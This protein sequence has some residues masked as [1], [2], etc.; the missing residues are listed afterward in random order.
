MQGHA[1]DLGAAAEVSSPVWLQLPVGHTPNGAEEDEAVE[2]EP[3]KIALPSREGGAQHSPLGGDW[4][5]GAILMSEA[6]PSGSPHAASAWPPMQLSLASALPPSPTSPGCDAWA[7]VSPPGFGVP[8]SPGSA[9]HH[10]G[11]CRPC[12][13]FWKPSGC[14]NGSDCAYCHL[15]P[16]GAGKA[17]A[18]AR[19]QEAALQRWRGAE[20]G[21]E[22]AAWAAMNFFATLEAARAFEVHEASPKLGSHTGRSSD[23]ETVAHASSAHSDEGELLAASSGTDEQRQQEDG[24]QLSAIANP[25]SALHAV[26]RCSPCAW[27]WKAV[28]CHRGPSCDHCHLCP[29]DERKNRK[30][31]KKSVLA[32][33]ERSPVST[34]QPPGFA[35]SLSALL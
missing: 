2:G 33:P 5:P 18:R 11:A 34:I 15:C 14:A 24:E 22:G 29:E 21:A 12:G 28:G 20:Q 25:G 6:S 10:S 1:D 3:L 19:K 8:P 7:E 35:L 26:G 23:A 4:T 32:T 9:L 13:W 30:K 16:A 17:R 27:F 31:N